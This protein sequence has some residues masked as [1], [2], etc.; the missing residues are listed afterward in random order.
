MNLFEPFADGKLRLEALLSRRMGSASAREWLL[1]DLCRRKLP[2]VDSLRMF[3]A[4]CGM[5]L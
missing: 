3:F 1:C 5:R 4:R 2:V